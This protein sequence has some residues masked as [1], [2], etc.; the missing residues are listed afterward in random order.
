[1]SPQAHGT[2]ST[3]PHNIR[4]A[5]AAASATEAAASAARDRT[6]P[7][8]AGEVNPPCPACGRSLVESHA[9][10]PPRSPVELEWPAAYCF[11]PVAAVRAACRTRATPR[12]ETRPKARLMK[13]AIIPRA[14]SCPWQNPK[15]PR[16]IDPFSAQPDTNSLTLRDFDYSG[17]T[18]RIR[19]HL[20]REALFRWWGPP[21]HIQPITPPCYRCPQGI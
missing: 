17:Y 14:R 19:K 10:S 9:L 5:A 1:M 4:H 15:R 20:N 8:H 13:L 6:T 7:A 2:S 16:L 12:K 3:T 21:K 11:K 18:P